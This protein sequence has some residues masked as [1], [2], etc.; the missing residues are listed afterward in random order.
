MKYELQ[1]YIYRSIRLRVK[2]EV[3]HVDS[4]NLSC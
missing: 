4:K 3:I 2:Q 1:Q